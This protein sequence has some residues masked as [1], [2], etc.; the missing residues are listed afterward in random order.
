MLEVRI[1]LDSHTG[2][3]PTAEPLALLEGR[4]LVSVDL[5]PEDPYSARLYA[6]PDQAE[7]LATTLIGAAWR[8]RSL[9][10]QF[11]AENQPPG[12]ADAL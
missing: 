4:W 8:A 12:A 9:T 11:K 6:T 3:G 5:D 1:H 7:A 10:A 2:P